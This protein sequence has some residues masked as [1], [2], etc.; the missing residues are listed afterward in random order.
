MQQEVQFAGAVGSE[1]KIDASY[2]SPNAGN[3]LN[4][5]AQLH[6]RMPLSYESYHMSSIPKG[7]TGDTAFLFV[8]QHC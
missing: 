1:F 3:L 5:V 2:L 4:A 8:G 6:S 7:D